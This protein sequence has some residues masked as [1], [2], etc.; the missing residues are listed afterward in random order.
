MS[1]SNNDN[2]AAHVCGAP[3]SGKSTLLEGVAVVTQNFDPVK[4]I[5]Q[6]VCGFHT[7]AHDIT[8]HVEA[9]HYCAHVNEDMHQ[10]VIYDS[11]KP[12]ARLIGIEY[13]ISERI[14]K[15]LPEEEKKLWHS[16]QFEVLSGMLV[17]PTAKLV[18]DIAARTAE[19]EEMKCLVTTYGKTWHTW[20][21]DRG[22]KLPLG[23]PQLMMSYT[24]EDQVPDS[25]IEARDRRL[26]I[27]TAVRRK[28]RE[29]IKENL[30]SKIPGCDIWDSSPDAKSV[31]VQ[32]AEV[33]VVRQ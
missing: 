20:Q 26:G 9:H 8:R 29:V 13:I 33:D 31:Q 28:D 15:D 22:D 23:P 32:V 21:V 2:P 1:E 18:P 11:E 7:Y 24:K 27:D 19:L 5:H 4:S 16:H 3:K 10:C 6:H 17:M 12:G 30:G 14:F 25:L